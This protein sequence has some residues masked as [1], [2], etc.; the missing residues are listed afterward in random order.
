MKIRSPGFAREECTPKRHEKGRQSIHPA[1]CPPASQ[2]LLSCEQALSDQG[3]PGLQFLLDHWPFVWCSIILARLV[4]FGRAPSSGSGLPGA[5]P[6]Q[7]I[8]LALSSRLATRV[9]RSRSTRR[10]RRQPDLRTPSSR[11]R[12]PCGYQ[13]TF[14][15]RQSQRITNTKPETTA[16]KMGDDLLSHGVYPAVPSALAGL[17]SLFGMGRGVSP[18]PSSPFQKSGKYILL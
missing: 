5:H 18:P 15:L 4:E 1:L 6:L 8:G 16:K 10:L 11:W 14:V 13:S 7:G 2:A 3:P 12:I 9:G 17:T